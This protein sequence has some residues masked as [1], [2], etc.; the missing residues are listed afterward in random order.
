MISGERNMG[1]LN[2]YKKEFDII[3]HYDNYWVR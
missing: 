1:K 3:L 2:G